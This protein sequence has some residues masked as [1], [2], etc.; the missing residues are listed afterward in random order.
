MR[1]RHGSASSRR[2]GIPKGKTRVSLERQ[3]G[4]GSWTHIGAANS[5]SSGSYRVSWNVNVFGPV[6]LRVTAAGHAGQPSG[7][8]M[9]FRRANA[10]IFGGPSEYQA[11]ACGGRIAKGTMGLAHK[12][13]ACGTLVRVSYGQ[14]SI[15]LP[16]IDRGPYRGGYTWDVTYDAAKYLR[17]NGSAVIGYLVSGRDGT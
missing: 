16:V 14:R 2:R 13:L 12:T 11:A 17:M 4:S 6:K 9:S 5:S 1:A 7:T 8:I 15:V 3:N 10:T